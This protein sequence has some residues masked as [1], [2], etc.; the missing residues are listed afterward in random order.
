MGYH[1]RMTT[2]NRKDFSQIAFNVAQIATGE[3]TKPQEL[4]G[5]KADSRKGGL[6]GG[7]TRMDQLTKEQRSELA[8][9]AVEA[10]W[11]NA[12]PA[13]KTSAAK[14]KLAKQR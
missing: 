11:K 5:K 14:P 1:S 8:K 4:T 9:K 10:R 2:N 13:T 12:A 6:K 3:A 7:K